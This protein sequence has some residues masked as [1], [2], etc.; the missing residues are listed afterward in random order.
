MKKSIHL[1]M[2]CLFVYG[3]AAEPI[4]G[5]AISFSSYSRRTAIQ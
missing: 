2:A 4:I 5:V 3:N 1:F